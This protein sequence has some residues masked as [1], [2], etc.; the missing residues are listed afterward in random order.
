ML[1]KNETCRRKRGSG[2]TEESNS[3]WTDTKS[4]GR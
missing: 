3:V 4:G 2:Q 1:A